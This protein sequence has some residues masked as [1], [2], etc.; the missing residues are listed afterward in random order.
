MFQQQCDEAES[1]KV[2]ILLTAG[3]SEGK[4]S[5]KYDTELDKQVLCFFFL[6]ECTFSCEADAGGV[7]ISPGGGGVDY[8]PA[9]NEVNLRA[10]TLFLSTS[11]SCPP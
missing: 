10:H 3:K 1:V 2:G 8:R 6:L 9:E 11:N 5:Q 4:L 7:A